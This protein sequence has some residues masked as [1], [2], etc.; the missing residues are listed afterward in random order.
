MVTTHGAAAGCGGA[1]IGPLRRML[2]SSGV[3]I[4]SLLVLITLV[5][6]PAGPAAASA[7]PAFSGGAPLPTSGTGATATGTV[8]GTITVTGAPKGFSPPFEGVGACPAGGPPQ[9]LCAAPRYLLGSPYTL[10]LPVGSWRLA[11]FYELAPFGG[12]FLGTLQTVKVTAGADLHI[13]VTVPY[14]VPGTVQGTVKVT[15]IP[16]GVTIESYLAL[17]CPSFAPF[18]GGSPPIA[19][20]QAGAPPSPTGGSYQ[21]T[22]L[23]PGVWTVYPG[24]STV[25]GLTIA[26]KAGVKTTVV[27]HRTKTV[28]VTTPY[29]APES[30]IL[31]GTVTVSGA[32]KGFTAP[33]GIEA[34]PVVVSPQ[35]CLGAAGSSSTYSL[36]L[37]AGAWMVQPLYLVPPFY[38]A[39]LGTKQKVVVVAGTTTTLNLTVA[40]VTLGTASGSVAVTGV[41]K[42][43]TIDQ[44]TVLACPAKTPWTGGTIPIGCVSEFSGY[45]G[46]G[47]I[48]VAL[49]RLTDK[50]SK[51]GGV[52]QIAAQTPF[53]VYKLPTLTTGSWFL[54]PGYATVF[55]SFTTLVGTKVAIKAGETTAQNLSVAYQTPVDGAMEGK[56]AVIGSP[57]G[58]AQT[59]VI[60]CSA[61]PTPTAC[62][63]EQLVFTD[64]GGAYQL[65]L[66][67]GQWWVEG[68]V[69]TFG[70]TGVP[71]MTPGP[72]QKLMIKAGVVTT[73]NFT[74]NAS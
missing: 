34:C 2:G 24:Y 14:R 54:Y 73:A 8:Q 41:P 60:A 23:P 33:V 71:T 6:V 66:L 31:T 29:I 74:V 57:G 27:S 4:A 58:G 19:C 50:G 44:Y 38:N 65:A 17:L 52:A 21:V 59:G 39:I 20:V 63:D 46:S 64:Q 32:P 25:F 49:Q 35:Q 36:T 3:G 7:E 13:N 62:P 16:T 22:T 67:A 47:V 26:A 68:V 9:K 69:V 48:S 70:L 28:N 43:T 53:N 30:G 40:Y 42:G 51:T 11:G 61:P 10:V 45:G 12:P 56:V 18:T 5:A 37:T 72:A 55:G 15:G 1:S